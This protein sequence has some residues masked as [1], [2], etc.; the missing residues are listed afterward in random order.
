M[1]MY[2]KYIKRIKIEKKQK[3]KTKEKERKLIIATEEIFIRLLVATI[4]GAIIGSDRVRRGGS[5]GTKTHSLVALGAAIT[6]IVGEILSRSGGTVSDMTRIAAQVVSGIGFLGAGTII[7]RA[8]EQIVGLT[9]AA[10]LW[11][12]GVMGIAAGAGIYVVV[13]LSMLL[14][15]IIFTILQFLDNNIQKNNRMVTA[16]VKIV[17]PLS[18]M[19]IKYY[20]TK[21]KYDVRAFSIENSDLQEKEQ[22][23]LVSCFL[24]REASLEEFEKDFN[25]LV[26]IKNIKI[27]VEY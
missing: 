1:K 2:V 5:A 26:G 27:L 25:K 6:V 7:V 3:I 22:H 14:W 13:A 16:Y 19:E 4:C 17:E 15:F 8:N 11:L 20:L 23:I 9:T 21:K 24:P 12:S 10:A 18:A